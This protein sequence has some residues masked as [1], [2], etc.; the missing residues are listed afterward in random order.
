MVKR[1]IRKSKQSPKPTTKK[2]RNVEA[3]DPDKPSNRE[4]GLTVVGI[5]ASAGGLNALGAFFNSVPSD[6]GMAFV[7]V[8]H[9]HPEHESHLAEL[10]Q[11][12][13]HMRTMQV[14]EKVQ[15]EADHVYVVPPNRS[16]IMTDTHLDTQEFDEPH[17]RRTPIDH[18]FRSM[19]ASGHPD[20]IAVIL[21]GGGTDGAVGVKDVKEVGGLIMVQH[22]DDAE[23]D[24]MPRATMSTGLVDVILPASQLAS[25]LVEY[26]QH[27]PKLPNDPGQLTD[28][29]MEILQSIIAQVHARTG[30]DFSQ[31][32]R[33]TILRRVERRMRLNGFITLEAYL[34]FLHGSANEAQA[35][36]NDI[37]IG[38]T[39]FFRDHDSWEALKKKV[40]PELFNK[41]VGEDGIRVW[42]IGC[43]TGEEAYTL[44]ILLFE[45]AEKQDF[46]THIQVF[47]SDLDERSIAHA[48]E[49][50]Y[51]AAIEA[52]VSPERLEKFFVREGEYYCVKRELRDAVLFTNHNVLRD[53]PFSRQDLITCRNVLI[54]LQRAVQ[55]RVFDIFNYSLLPD[56]FLF[57]GTSESAEHIPDLFTVVDKP[58]RIYQAKAWV[59]ERPHVPTI[60]LVLNKTRRPHELGVNRSQPAHFME[61]PILAE[62]QHLRALETYGPPSV[63]VNERY[64]IQHVSETAG[65]YLHLPKGPIT[66]DLLTLV[67]P[68]LHLELQ[69][70]L[71]HAFEKGKSTASRPVA[72]QF[73][74]H[75][76]WVVMAVRPRPDDVGIEKFSERQALVVFIEDE[77]EDPDEVSEGVPMP[78]NQ[79]ERDDVVSQQQAE[80]QRLREQLQ[81][82]MEEYE[83]SNEEMKAANEELQSINEEYRSATEELE[84][85]K[86]EL[87]SVNEELQTVNTE[88]RNK[89]DEVSQAHRELENLMG[90]TE[91]PMLYLDRELRIQRF[92]AGVQDIFNIL[93]VDRG[94]RISDLTHKMEYN[95]F[96][97]DAEQVLRMLIPVEHELMR[98]DGTWFLMRLH[99]YR[100]VEDHIEGVVITF[101]DISELKETEQELVRAKESLEE[102]VKER[103]VALDEANYKLTQARD[104]FQALFNANPIPTALTRLEDEVIL[105]VNIQFLNYFGLPHEEA[106]GRRAGE[107]NLLLNGAGQDQDE[108]ISMVKQNG[109]V[110]DFEYELIHPS[111]E[112]RNILAS[113]QNLMVD[114]TDTVI[115]TFIDITERVRAERQVRSLASDLTAAEQEERKRI[116][117]ILHDDLQQRIFAVK[118][119]L[120]TLVDALQ[121][122]DGQS[123]QLDIDQLQG[124]LDESISITRNLSIDL[125]PAILQGDS[126]VDALVW[127][128]N[129]MLEQYGL[130]VTVESNGISTR[131][132]DTLR[133]LL[134]QAVREALFNVIKHAGTLSARVSFERTDDQIRVTISDDGAGFDANAITDE[135]G[136]LLNVRHRLGLMGCRMHINSSPGNGSLVM[137]DIPNQKVK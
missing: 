25:K 94:R 45:E 104:L 42:S 88:M 133:I 27:R 125:S 58:H 100:T 85:S 107:F 77:V 80:L 126:L 86:E 19:A 62:E 39:N 78:R 83:S 87:Q 64:V 131:F 54:Y 114:H 93:S 44:A 22:P 82:I 124:L 97:D 98:A 40:M 79:G 119:Q 95:R 5:G 1:N 26:I 121:R 60:P 76:R 48:R 47:A 21:S 69:T 102:R 115:S 130:K 129:Q 127:L 122:G 67:R 105:D 113:V 33:S 96:M 24:S 34:S 118:V 89:L 32:K 110:R 29:E 15:V 8:T 28:P 59:G 3:P 99:P 17:G 70:A 73:N 20:L 134:F 13:T 109:G 49:G 117:Q 120:S 92:T 56:G 103:T 81:I 38:V 4:A 37:L 2:P 53:P 123:V 43:A 31:Y 136:G 75:K 35:M 55:D 72:V 90:A 12:H 14:N 116:S 11:R 66:G 52:D 63:I 36:F 106:I 84:T 132:E 18:F 16:I 68:E 74:G 9:L 7:V 23:Y 71:F 10:L 30:H 51:P 128:S 135:Q 91:I 137:I 111:G 6:T 65:R 46:H 108:L 41:N 112:R 50:L 61:G 57:L 101:I